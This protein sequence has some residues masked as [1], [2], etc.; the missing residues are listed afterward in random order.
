MNETL[1]PSTLS[2]QLKENVIS[3]LMTT[4]NIKNTGFVDAFEKHIRSE[5]GLFRGPYI[6]VKLPF[7]TAASQSQDMFDLNLQFRPFEHQVKAFERL[8]SRGRSPK[9]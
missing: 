7:R 1:I 3:Y 8:T 5:S 9:S 2:H 4:F 6:D